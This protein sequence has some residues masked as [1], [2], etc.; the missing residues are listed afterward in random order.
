MR[1]VSKSVQRNSYFYKNKHAQ[2]GIFRGIVIADYCRFGE[3]CFR[4][5]DV[6][7]IDEGKTLQ[8]SVLINKFALI[9]TLTSF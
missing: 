2:L 7:V 5:N 3:F 8:M 6:V 9:L 1:A 4:G